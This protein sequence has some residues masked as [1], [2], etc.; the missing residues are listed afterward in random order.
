MRI[1]NFRGED[2][3]AMSRGAQEVKPKGQTNDACVFH[4]DAKGHSS[5]CDGILWLRFNTWKEE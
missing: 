5:L 3:R 4:V 2:S 1:C